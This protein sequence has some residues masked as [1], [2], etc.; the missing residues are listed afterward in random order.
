[1]PYG[2]YISAEGAQAQAAR[3][4]VIANNLANVD[5]VGFKRDLALFQARYA[6][7]TER[8]IDYPGSRTINDVGGGVVVRETRTQHNPGPMADTGN[9]TDMAIGGPGFFMVRDGQQDY[10]TRAGNFVL[11]NTGALETQ[12]GHAVLDDARQPIQIDPAG[13][14][15]DVMTDGT[16][17][18][19][20]TNIRLAL[21]EPPSLGDLA[22]VGENRF[23]PLA[24][25]QPVPEA[26]RRVLNRRLEMS[27]VKPALEMMDMIEASRA[28]E[29]NV[30]LIRNQDQMLG[31]LINRVMR[32]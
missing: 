21:V 13:P 2:M 5:T 22:K 4:N 9:V 20:G 7:E 17:S 14:T 15:W 32:T 29:A 24:T 31:T 1:M 23:M 12:E 6:E 18:Q 16:I 27:G 10:L 8:G 30:N 25:T 28:F 11:S 3:L 26:D 19:A